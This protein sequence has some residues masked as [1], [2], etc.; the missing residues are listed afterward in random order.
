MEHK[1]KNLI[2]IL[3]YMSIFSCSGKQEVDFL[4]IGLEEAFDVA[5][6][7][8]KLVM[9]DFFSKTCMPCVRLVNT[10]FKDKLISKY[11]NQQFISVKLTADTHDN[12]WELREYYNVV[13][14]PTVIF[15]NSEGNEIDRNCGFNGDKK[16]YYQ[17]IKDYVSNKNTLLILLA[18]YKSDSLS[19]ENNYNLA[20][21]YVTRDELIKSYQYF[22]NV[23]NFDKNDQYGYHEKSQLYLALYKIRFDDEKSLLLNIIA[24]SDNN[25]DVK[26][27][28]DYLFNFYEKHKDTSNYIVACNAAIS[29]LPARDVAYWRLLNHYKSINDIS[30]YLSTCKIAI[31]NMPSNSSY[32][33]N[34]AR[35]V[36]QYKL[37]DNYDEAIEISKTALDINPDLDK[38]WYTLSLIYN[39]LGYSDNATKA[40]EAAIKINP[41]K[42]EYKSTLKKYDSY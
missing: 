19:I 29:R 31:A 3:I 18:N 35:A 12:Y 26:L 16:Q 9:V 10:V 41:N 13:G 15:F 2:F 17:T 39:E 37:I 11:I 30:M 4:S 21:K 5:K 32:Y 28:Y 8:D 22:S 14:L 1:M 27:G 6:Q 20:M 7:K 24:N 36:Y 42:E 34:Y 25:E 40:I 38:I 33:R 23:L